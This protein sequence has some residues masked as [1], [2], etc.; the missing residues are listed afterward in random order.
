MATPSLEERIVY[1]VLQSEHA[2]HGS[3]EHQLFSVEQLFQKNM[4]GIIWEAPEIVSDSKNSIHV[5]TIEHMQ[6]DAP[7][8]KTNGGFYDHIDPHSAKLTRHTYSSPIVVDVTHRIYSSTTASKTVVWETLDPLAVDREIEAVEKGLPVPAALPPP[9]PAPVPA[10]VPAPTPEPLADGAAPP[11]AKK[12]RRNKI[13]DVLPAGTALPADTWTLKEDRKFRQVVQF[14]MPV[15]VRGGRY[16]HGGYFIVKGSEKVVLSQKR[17]QTNRFYVFPST[18]AAWTWM[19]EIRA[20]HSAKIRSTSTLRVNIHTGTRG[21]G[22]IWGVVEIPYVD[23]PIPVMAICRLLGFRNAEEV[24]TAAATGGVLS[25]KT[26]IR[27]GSLWDVHA[28]HTTRQWI[29]SL[30]KDDAHK[31]PCFESMSRTAILQWVGEEGTKRKGTTD[32]SK[33]VAHLMA[34]EFLPQMGLESNP[35][36]VLRKAQMFAFMLWRMANVARATTEA[37]DRDHAGNKQYD[38]PGM[39][40]ALLL[41]QHYRNFRKK[42]SSEIRRISDSGRFVSIPDLMNIKRMTDGF[43]YALSTGNWGLQKGGSTQTGVAQMLSRINTIATV[44]HLRRV[45]TPLKREGKQARPRHINTSSFGNMCPAE[46]PEGPACGLVEQMAQCVIYCGGYAADKLI[47]RTAH[48]L[49]GMLFPLIEPSILEGKMTLLPPRPSIRSTESYVSRVTVLEHD[50]EEWDA[51]EAQQAASDA[52]LMFESTDILRVIVNGVLIGFVTDGPAAVKALR[53]GRRRNRLPF[54]VAIENIEVL[55]VLVINGEAGGIRRPLFRLDAD[56]TLTSVA[57]LWERTQKATP[58]TLWRELVR[59]GVVEYVS[60]HEEETLMILES[61]H[62]GKLHAPLDA[63]THCELHPSV[64]L[65]IAAAMIPF[66]DH[67]QAPRTTYF[68]SMSKQ[69]AGNPGPDTPYTNALRLWYP[70]HPLV[71]TWATSIHK[72]DRV[73]SGLNAWV[74]VAADG[75]ENQED[76]LYM[77]SDSAARGLF[78]CYVIRNHTE[79]CQTGSGADAQRF[80]KP[81]VHCFGR[82]VGNYEKLNEQGFVPP[83]THLT[84]GDAFIGKTMDVNEMGCIKRSTIRRDQSIMLNSRDHATTVDSVTRCKGRDDK[85]MVSVQMH[86]VRFLKPGDKLTSE[87]G[88]KGVCGAQRRQCDMPYTADGLVADLV[89]NPHAFPS[90]MT[91]GQIM[92]SALGLVCARTGETGDGTPFRGVSADDINVEL[93]AN[94][95]QTMGDTVMYQGKTGRP[96]KYKLFFGPT[97]YFRVKQMVDDKHHARARG[98]VH[99]LTQQPMEGR[100]KYGGL[101]IGEM[102]RD[103]LQ[104]HGAGFAMWDRLF[105]QSDYAEIPVCRACH[106][107]A[108]PRAPPGQQHITF[109]V[110]ETAGY[111]ANCRTAGNVYNTPMPYVDKL[112]S[113]ELMTMH[114]RPEILIDVNPCVDVHAAASV[115]ILKKDRDSDVMKAGVQQR[116]QRPGPPRVQF[117]PVV[118]TPAGFSTGGQYEDGGAEERKREDVEPLSPPYTPLSYGGDEPVSPPYTPMSYGGGVSPP[119]TPLSYGGGV[120]PPYTPLSYGGDEPVSPPYTPIAGEG[121]DEDDDEEGD[122]EGEELADSDSI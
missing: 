58:D 12:R 7:V 4:P 24:A 62:N 70:Q 45:N 50:G 61:P 89:I 80:E 53:E 55:G 99:V 117:A 113:H 16:D 92:S 72:F 68:T 118:D 27:K 36:T 11:V 64:M 122:G 79:D 2:V 96:V 76:S 111:C 107:I 105:Q 17:L 13:L 49:G 95:F 119:Y 116:R 28:V 109:G 93:K 37:D 71:T 35:L 91:I 5:I 81:P 100:A 110:N 8:S 86:T 26:P 84:G 83:G 97:Y 120:S 39:L 102:E 23:S 19:G 63:Y 65:G 67:N 33:Y 44:S 78:A 101:R 59:G 104:A 21:S 46:T 88:Q 75:G 54:D 57:K 115:G 94:G 85:D 32:R 18:K 73:P 106:L 74:A 20:C 114:I 121:A 48:L 31:F 43:T 77:N 15:M 60:K 9:A 22:V 82:K 90:R 42:L 10:P 47:R 69:T 103:C 34:N 66:S 40:L 41:R 6:V 38:T 29:L 56:G 52:R 51:A 3:T 14:H 1:D 87:H 112:L 98:P 25:G 30:L 108:M